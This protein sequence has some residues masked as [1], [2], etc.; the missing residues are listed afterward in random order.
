M[1]V[2]ADQKVLDGEYRLQ[3]TFTEVVPH[4]FFTLTN[5]YRLVVDFPPVV[6]EADLAVLEASPAVSGA[7]FGLFRPEEARLVIDLAGPFAVTS[8]S[9]R[10]EGDKSIFEIVL[11]P[12]SG[13]LYAATAGWPEG[14]KWEVPEID[15]PDYAANDVIIAIDPGHGG[16]D[17]GA[18]TEDLLEKDVVLSVGLALAD[19]INREPGFTAVL[20][21]EDDRFVPLRGRLDIAHRAGAHVMISL[22]ADS[23]TTGQADGVSIYTLSEKASDQATREFAEREN[24]VD[25]L[26]GA[27]LVGETDDVTRLLLDL[28]RRGNMPETDKLARALLS[29]LKTKVDMIDTRPYRQ[30]GFYVLKSPDIPSVLV[31]LGFLSSEADRERLQ[32][33]A[34]AKSIAE[35]MLIGLH[36]WRAIA[37]PAFLA[38]RN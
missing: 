27:N 13:D 38:P 21:R 35:A 22:H 23:I 5:P 30:A 9:S 11:S 16:F 1:V 24:R 26:A 28:S 7:R 29:S 3:F 33:P 31:E 2:A 15:I 20:T 36:R 14:E 25:I 32:D 4:E 37:D 8:A 18:T 6:W 17:P 12:I 19:R 34:F 10:D